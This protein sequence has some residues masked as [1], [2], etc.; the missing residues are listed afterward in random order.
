MTNK[1]IC[2]LFFSNLN[3]DSL[4]VKKQLQNESCFR[5]VSV[6]SKEIRDKLLADELYRITYIPTILEVNQ[7]SDDLKYEGK[8]VLKWLKNYNSEKIEEKIKSSQE[9]KECPFDMKKNLI[10]PLDEKEKQEQST[11]IKETSVRKDIGTESESKKQLSVFEMAQ[12][13][14]KMRE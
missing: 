9:N 12:A 10:Q 6:D 11:P 3:K 7:N 2:I 1:K 5:F 8:E 14:Q 13:M 4:Q